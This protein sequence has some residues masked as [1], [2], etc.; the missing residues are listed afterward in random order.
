MKNI[1]IDTD[2]GGDCDDAGALLLAKTAAERGD[3][4][5]GAVTSC[6]TMEGAG[7]CI[8]GI[9]HDYGM[10]VPIGLS[11][12]KPFMCGKRFNRY[13]KAVQDRYPAEF[14]WQNSVALLKE[15]LGSGKRYTL[16]GI[17]PQRNLAALTD[18]DG[19]A[20]IEK[21]VDE[22][23]IMGGT[24]I[25]PP[26]RF[27]RKRIAVE[28]NIAQ[29]VEAAR[30]FAARCPVPI[31][32]VPFEVGYDISTGKNIPTD[33]VAGLAYALRG[34]NGRR[35][36]W[37]PCA[38][39]YAVYGTDDLFALSDCGRMVFDEQGKSTFHVGQGK[40]R[41]LLQKRSSGEIANRLDE[42]IR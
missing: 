27:E 22:V 11:T 15:T 17:G 24:V 13:A 20:L 10:A 18:P 41:I 5:I 32:Y 9:F 33:S 35:A 38:V 16:V 25:T 40:H 30:T 19:I 37:D 29:D 42:W 1:L 28:W 12:G 23:V 36:S 26:V 4:A 14:S 8:Y 6:T 2:I 7:A 31:T 39:Y 21:A 34:E 3:V